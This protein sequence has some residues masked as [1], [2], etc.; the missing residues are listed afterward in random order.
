LARLES[1]YGER[2]YRFALLEAGHIAQNLLLAATAEGVAALPVGGFVEDKLNA[3]LGLNGRD[4]F[5]VYLILLGC[6]P[7]DERKPLGCETS[8]NLSIGKTA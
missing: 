3:L 1:K 5:A 7:E 4:E 2:S 6:P 8:T